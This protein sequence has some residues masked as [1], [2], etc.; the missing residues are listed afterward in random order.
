MLLEEPSKKI[1]K[2]ELKL[3]KSKDLSLMLDS[4]EKLSIRFI[5]F[6]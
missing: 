4:E 2:K 1:K 5:L 3:Q 6:Y